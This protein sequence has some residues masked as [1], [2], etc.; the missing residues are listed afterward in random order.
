MGKRKKTGRKTTLASHIASKNDI[1]TKLARA[2]FGAKDDVTAFYTSVRIQSENI[3]SLSKWRGDK[4]SDELARLTPPSRGLVEIGL[5]VAERIERRDHKF[6]TRIA[7]LLKRNAGREEPHKLYAD[8]LDFCGDFNCG[9]EDQPCPPYALLNCLKKMGWKFA[10]LGD[11]RFPPA[12]RATC[13]RIG[14]V[15]GDLQKGRPKK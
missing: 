10:D 3:R 1:S 5:L 15:L 8:I 6:F 2:N 9:T 11:N 7:A 4:F 13:T 12:L 14:I